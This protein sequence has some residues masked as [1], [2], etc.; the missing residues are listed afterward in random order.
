MGSRTRSGARGG[1][2]CAC[3]ATHALG[4]RRARLRATRLRVRGQ[5]RCRRPAQA[6]GR[7]TRSRAAARCSGPRQPAA[8]QAV[9]CR[10]RQRRRAARG[11]RRGDRQRAHRAGGAARQGSRS[12]TRH[13]A[14][15]GACTERYRRAPE[16]RCE[17]ARPPR[18]SRLSALACRGGLEERSRG[19]DRIPAE[20][21]PR[22]DGRHYFVEC[23]HAVLSPR[24]FLRDRACRESA[25]LRWWTPP[26]RP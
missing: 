3:G 1:N 15:A 21:Q 20:H 5:R 17:S 12:R 2:R 11:Y 16:S 25:D 4:Q 26:R 13:R 14:P 7:R 9:R 18:R 24:A 19:Q 6:C 23:R 22:R 8:G 10:G